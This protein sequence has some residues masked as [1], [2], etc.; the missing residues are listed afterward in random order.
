MGPTKFNAAPATV[1]QRASGMGGVMTGVEEAICA[2]APNVARRARRP[3]TALAIAAALL[4][5]FAT[6]A[7][8][9][10]EGKGSS[11]ATS[12]R[13]AREEAVRMIPWKQMTPQA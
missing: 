7:A 13:A 3:Q 6:S 4:I 1:P 5:G 12:S 2:S 10:E 9:Q 11:D 8:A